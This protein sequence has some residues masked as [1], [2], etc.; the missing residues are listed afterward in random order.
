MP[1][2]I[3]PARRPRGDNAAW[4]F[5]RMKDW[6]TT[7]IGVLTI[8]GTLITAALSYLHGQPVDPKI[9]I[10]GFGAGAGLIAANDSGN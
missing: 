9:L 3:F 10:A 5:Y 7:A 6:K 1:T 8:L 4:R 2:G